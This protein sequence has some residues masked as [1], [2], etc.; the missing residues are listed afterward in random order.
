[1]EGW[2]A[3]KAEMLTVQTEQGKDKRLKIWD[4]EKD[5]W[6]DLQ[7]GYP[8]R[9]TLLDENMH[10]LELG[11][12]PGNAFDILQTGNDAT[13]GWM[14]IRSRGYHTGSLEEVATRLAGSSKIYYRRRGFGNP[15]KGEFPFGYD[16]QEDRAKAWQA[17]L[18]R[19]LTERAANGDYFRIGTNW[20]KFSDNGWSYWLE[21]YNF[22]LVTMKDNAYDG[23]EATKLGADGTPGTLDDEADD[24]GDFLTGVTRANTSI[25]PF[26]QQHDAAPR[27]SP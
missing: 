17:G 15:G 26:L 3:P 21:R 18:H 23:R 27:T 7:R 22:G 14:M 24:Y 5:F 2:L 16:T 20:W 19:D 12:S 6:F 11:K 10:M 1:L 13:G 4:V 9:I 25:Y 8:L